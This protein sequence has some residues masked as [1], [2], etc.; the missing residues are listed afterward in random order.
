[1]NVGLKK[2]ERQCWAQ[3]CRTV[4]NREE[5]MEM[6]VPDA[7][8]D[9]LEIVDTEG[10]LQLR[11][12]EC[13]EGCIS[14]SGTVQCSILYT[15]EEGERLC[16]LHAE[17]PFQ[18]TADAE[19]VTSRCRCI[20]RPQVTM[21]ETRAINPRKVLVRVGLS[22]E[23]A[24]NEPSSMACTCGIE[25]ESVS[26]QQ[27]R[28]ERRLSLVTFVGE[29]SFPVTDELQ[30]P[31]S[32]PPM[33]ELLRSRCRAFVSESRL[34]GGKLL[35]KGGVA[36][37]LLYLDSHGGLCTAELELPF[38]QIVDAGGAGDNAS[39]DLT[40]TVTDAIVEPSDSD[41][42]EVA[43]ELELLLQVTVREEQ[44]MPLVTDAYCIQGGGEPEFTPVLLPKLL[45]QSTRRQNCRELLETS[46][47][48]QEVC[49]PRAVAG[50]VRLMGEELVTEVHLSIL[51]LTEEDTYAAVNRTIQ[52]KCPVSVA[53]S[54]KIAA[55]CEL[56]ELDATASTGGI[57]L[58]LGVD[59]HW[60]LLEEE[61]VCCLTAFSV[62]AEQKPR[63]EHQPSIV[64]R[65]ITAGETLWD[66]AKA[67]LTTCDE[68]R[69]ANGLDSERMEEGRM[70][71]IPKKR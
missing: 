20:L 21:A 59:F 11:G 71:L 66:I 24:A 41:G 37:K 44:T 9:I 33:E 45:E 42:R 23:V 25:E 36:I 6:I 3:R 61:N 60:T 51:Y 43:A 49:D 48:A 22:F 1:M 46:V 64:L 4:L 19:G 38:S 67:Y 47:L 53:E 5:T 32:R 29:K 57:E 55:Y 39:Y 18:F 56:V 30:L 68:I 52:V 2:E 28:E 58:R 62:D 69:L 65:Q 70:L 7:C 16:T 17:V 54:A 15:P 34:T 35:V 31:G 50:Q 27:R 63:Q 13:A 12:K 10:V 40:A 14:L 26:I 8:P